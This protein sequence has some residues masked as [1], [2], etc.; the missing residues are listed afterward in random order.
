MEE[1]R[2]YLEKLVVVDTRSVYTYL[3]TLVNAT[4][5]FLTLRDVDVHDQRD[6]GTTRELYIIESVK[7][8][9]KVNRREVKVA[10]REI[11]SVSLLADIVQY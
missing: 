4:P 7:F 11:V 2:A 9:I 6:S 3:G 5:D 10:Q 1:L 8:G